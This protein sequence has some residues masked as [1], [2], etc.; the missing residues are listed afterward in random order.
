[1]CEVAACLF[2]YLLG[3]KGP[4]FRYELGEGG[5]AEAVAILHTALP[6]DIISWKGCVRGGRLPFPSSPGEQEASG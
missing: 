1:M 3:R 6:G 4:P 2:P 5:K